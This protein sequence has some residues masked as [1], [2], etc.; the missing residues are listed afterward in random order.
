MSGLSADFRGAAICL[1]R[2]HF[3]GWSGRFFHGFD[4]LR[5]LWLESPIAS[6]PQ[7]LAPPRRVL[8]PRPSDVGLADTP[9][10]PPFPARQSS[11]SPHGRRCREAADEGRSPRRCHPHPAFGHPLPVGEGYDHP[12]P[13]GRRCREA[14][15]EG[16]SPRRC[17]PHPAFGP[18]PHVGFP[19]LPVG[20]AYDH[21]M[22]MRSWP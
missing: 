16:R 20:E 12:S 10:F 4:G 1:F 18:T 13:H 11:P 3:L 15:D 8:L 5:R 2:T 7:F 19:P 9:C 6:S 14:A 22:L 21:P 17:R